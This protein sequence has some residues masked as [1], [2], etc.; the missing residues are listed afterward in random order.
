MAGNQWMIYGAN[1]Y[2]G[3][4]LLDHAV[5]RGERPLVAGRRENAI[6]PLA[7]KY[8]LPFRVFGLD[9]PDATVQ[10]MHGI[11]TLLLAAGP[12]S[13]T[14]AP[15][16]SACLK[17]HTNYLD[18]TGEIAVFEAVQRRDTDAKAA[19]VTLLPGAGF[20]VVPSDC[21]AMSLHKE[22][23]EATHLSLA[24]AVV[25]SPGPGTVK[26]AVEGAA[27]GGWIR[28]AGKLERVPAAWRRAKIPFAHGARWAMTIPWGDVSTAYWSTQIPDIEVFMAVPR[29]VIWAATLGRPFLGL[30]RNATAQKTL[31]RL[32]DGLVTGGNEAVRKAGRS[33]VWG[34]VED[35]SGR[36][37]EGN[38]ESMET[39]TLTAHTAVEIAVRL[40]KGEAAPGYTTPS[41]AFGAEFIRSFAHTR[42]TLE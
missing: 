18:I 41:L 1:G 30:L 22:L 16:I 8:G 26:T 31:K 35:S 40:Q 15:A 36:R 39:T 2:T 12:F 33:W 9:D 13:A 6:R 32:I 17:T 10:A 7:E 29:P 21:L 11:G 5:T 3:R 4:L 20:D 14:S 24:I 42:M 19:G 37:V 27:E 34:R 25:G 38:V 23:P 28:R